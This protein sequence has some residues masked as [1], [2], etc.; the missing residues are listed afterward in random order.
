MVISAEAKR[1]LFKLILKNTLLLYYCCDLINSKR[2][3]TQ[4]FTTIV[5]QCNVNTIY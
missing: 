3:E 2:I 4:K 5:Y 1:C